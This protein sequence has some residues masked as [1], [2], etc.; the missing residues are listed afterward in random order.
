MKKLRILLA[1]DNRGD[2]IL[3]R[4]ALR[5]HHIDH[6]LHVVE[7][8]EEALA[9]V[10]RLGNTDEMPCP[11]IVL[12]DLNLPKSDGTTVLAA[13]RRRPESASVPVIVVTS[14]AAPADQALVARLGISRYFQKPSDYEEFMRLESVIRDVAGLT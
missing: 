10:A 6:E 7:D 8:G 13:L 2:V 12:L 11:D 3:V 5:E 1:E 14:S 9:Y 4:E